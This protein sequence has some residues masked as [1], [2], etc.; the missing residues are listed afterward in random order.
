M[1]SL[2]PQFPGKLKK[3]LDELKNDLNLYCFSRNNA[4]RA[5]VEI[6]I[7]MLKQK[8]EGIEDDLWQRLR[9]CDYD[10]AQLKSNSTKIQELKALTA[11]FQRASHIEQNESKKLITFLYA[12]CKGLASIRQVMMDVTTPSQEPQ[13]LEDR[14][15]QI[16][17]AHSFNASTTY[18]SL[19]TTNETLA[20]LHS[21]YQVCSYRDKSDYATKADPE[22]DSTSSFSVHPHLEM[23]DSQKTFYAR[24][25]SNNNQLLQG[26]YISQNGTYFTS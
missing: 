2:P 23:S 25:S 10:L 26:K 11:S 18:D 13:D 7:Q 22:K 8:L 20:L 4:A 12:V 5:K 1:N 19:S 15:V 24:Q 17:P 6:N 21:N 3:L 9:R 14:M 16:N